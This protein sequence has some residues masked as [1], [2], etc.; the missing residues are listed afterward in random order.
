VKL[1]RRTR[2]IIYLDRNRLHKYLESMQGIEDFPLK[3]CKFTGSICECHMLASP[4]YPGDY[5]TMKPWRE[6]WPKRWD[7]S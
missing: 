6:G 3:P 5:P 4:E 2:A 1:S 7:D